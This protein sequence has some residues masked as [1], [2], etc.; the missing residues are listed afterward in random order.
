MDQMRMT[1]EEWK[2]RASSLTQSLYRPFEKFICPVTGREDELDPICGISLDGMA[3]Q[4][5]LGKI[6]PP[7]GWG[8][9]PA[10][11]F[12]TR[13]HAQR[14]SNITFRTLHKRYASGGNLVSFSEDELWMRTLSKLH[15]TIDL[16]GKEQV[17]PNLWLTFLRRVTKNIQPIYLPETE[18]GTE[19]WFS[20]ECD[21]LVQGI[22][23]SLHP[24][25]IAGSVVDVPNFSGSS[26]AGVCAEYPCEVPLSFRDIDYLYTQYLLSTIPYIPLSEAFAWLLENFFPSSGANEKVILPSIFHQMS[27]AGSTLPDTVIRE[28][29]G[30]GYG[31]LGMLKGESQHLGC[32]VKIPPL[33]IRTC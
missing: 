3:S 33:K 26:S 2:A 21:I 14:I 18:E 23:C 25:T 10:I 27:S 17:I 12:E 15:G 13:F 28:Y 20:F 5:R 22:W 4:V 24:P 30:D 31:F 6:Q 11:G 32:S 1:E 29:L 19:E 16:A 8:L 9:N 7:L